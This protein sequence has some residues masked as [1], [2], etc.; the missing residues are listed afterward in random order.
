MKEI[1]GIQ[2]GKG[3]VKVLLFAD[4]MIV[5]TSD[6]QNSTRN[7]LQLINTFGEVA[8]CKIKLKKKLQSS[9]IQKKSG[10]QHPSQHPQRI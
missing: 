2:I 1:E 9:Y 8:G 6:P 10:K 5:Y 7:H 4:D 3:D